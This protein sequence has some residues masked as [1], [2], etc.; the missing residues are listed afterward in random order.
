METSLLQIRKNLA[1]VRERIA[2]SENRAGRPPGS[3]KLIGVTKYV[4][5]AATRELAA[6]GCLDLAESRPQQLWTKAE[7]LSD[8]PV[9]WHLI[10]HLQR[11]KAKKTLEY[12]RILHS[13]DS[14]RLLKQIVTDATDLAFKADLDPT[15]QANTAIDL[16]LEVNATSDQSKTG[17]SFDEGRRLMQL[18]SALPANIPVKVTGLMGM[19]SLDATPDQIRREFELIR[20]TRDTWQ[21]EFGIPL[22]E[23]S[24]GMSDD[25]EIAIEHGSTMVRIGSKLFA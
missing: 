10:G 17:L 14:E 4:D 19:S 20:T 8:L 21:Q 7:S 11:N 23:L 24:M 15:K 9:R 6:L 25:F 2:E 5:L 1:N 3:V 22:P 12:A 18:A 16:L 13:I